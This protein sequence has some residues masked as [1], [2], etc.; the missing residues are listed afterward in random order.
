MT[1]GPQYGRRSSDHDAEFLRHRIGL[2]SERLHQH[3]E[4]SDRLKVITMTILTALAIYLAIS[5]FGPW[6]FGDTVRHLASFAGCEVTRQVGLAGAHRGQPGYW[7]QHDTNQDGIA[8]G[9]GDA[10]D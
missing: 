1:H 9:A 4:I 3:S 8:C 10:G 5:V 7:R 2:A 6:R